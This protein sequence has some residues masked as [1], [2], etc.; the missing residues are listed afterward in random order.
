MLGRKVNRSG[1]TLIE[2]L[3]VISII[4]ILIGLL[5][6]ALSGARLASRGVACSNNVKQLVITNMVFTND[7]KG[8]MPANRMLL[9]DNEHVTWRA[10]LARKGYLTDLD[11]WLCPAPPASE[12]MS[13]QGRPVGGSM[14]VCDPPSNYVFNGELMWKKD[15]ETHPISDILIE[16]V[17]RSTEV[18]MVMESRSYWPDLRYNS[19]DGRGLTPYGEDDGGG[20]FS[21]WH[22][23]NGGYYG[24]FDGHVEYMRLPELAGDVC[25]WHNVREPRGLHKEDWLSRMADAYK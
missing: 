25:H 19:V 5:L 12:P 9:N 6:P 23:N 4:S 15:Y 8:R 17:K 18:V 7:W 11:A 16:Q 14:C 22:T 24:M 2:L 3:V 13:E 1:F 10:F 21:Y 20:Y